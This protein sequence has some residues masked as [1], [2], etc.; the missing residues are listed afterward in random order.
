MNREYFEQDRGFDK[1]QEL[2]CQFV[3]LTS[4]GKSQI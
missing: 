4:N 1:C 3:V 2:I